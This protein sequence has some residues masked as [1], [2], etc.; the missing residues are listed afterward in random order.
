MENYS[1]VIFADMLSD[2]PI[3]LCL[4]ESGEIYLCKVISESG[5]LMEEIINVMTK[6]D[7]MIFIATST[8]KAMSIINKQ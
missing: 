3:Y 8:C 1:A 2:G 5:E 7:A 4:R 6:E